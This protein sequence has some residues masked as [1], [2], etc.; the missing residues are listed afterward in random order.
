MNEIIIKQPGLQ[1]TIQ[2]LGRMTHQIDGFPTSGC[3]DTIS[4]MTANI[5]VGNDQ[6]APVIEFALT[7]PTILFKAPTFIAVSGARFPLALNGKDISLNQCIYVHAND[8]LKIG[9]TSQGRYGY[10]AIREGLVISKVLDSYST[11]Q[12]LNIGG[13]HGRALRSGDHINIEPHAKL[14]NYAH[15]SIEVARYS[16]AKKVMRIRVL[17]GPQWSSFTSTDQHLF[18]SQRY[19][20]TFQSDRM[21]YRLQGQPLNIRSQNMLSEA[22]VNGGIQIPPDGQPIIL[23]A[24]RQTTGGYPVIAVVITA[25]I[26]KLIQCQ[27]K[28]R[29]CFENVDLQTASEILQQQNKQLAQLNLEINEAKFQKP[30]GINRIAA[31]RIQTLFEEA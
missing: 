12:R 16:E 2:D 15:R 8:L 28:Q 23:L 20:L 5:L 10:L 13:F 14:S 25:D 21:G 30:F 6:N 17:T 9:G 22:T 31:Q 11:T 24:D 3:M 27:P 26:P 18:L 29:I 7:G 1:S 19:Q 4:S